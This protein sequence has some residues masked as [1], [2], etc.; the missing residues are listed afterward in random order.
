MKFVDMINSV[1]VA[2][3]MAFGPVSTACAEPGSVYLDLGG[4]T[5][6]SDADQGFGRG[7]GLG[8]TF[9]VNEQA[10]LQL[11]MGYTYI[12]ALNAGPS[13]RQQIDAAVVSYYAPYQGGFRP[14]VG[15]HAGFVQT[16]G[17]RNLGWDLGMDA[18]ALYDIPDRL[19][20]YASA[21]PAFLFDQGPW[22]FWLRMG[23]G[24]RLRLRN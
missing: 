8:L 18:M 17:R 5:T 13:T 4:R 9:G 3:C 7:G 11:R 16:N 22:D 1:L 10:E 24:I 14:M 19:Q 12:P 6:L 15:A 2:L 20:I 21:T 23:L